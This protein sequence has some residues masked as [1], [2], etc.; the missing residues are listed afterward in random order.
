MT[1]EKTAGDDM[2]FPS[3]NYHSSLA[4]L[5]LT[6]RELF[7]AMAMQGMTASCEPCDQNESKIAQWAVNKA[8][9]LI[10]ALNQ[11]PEP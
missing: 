10:A 3:D 5:G 1:S 6:K 8:D 7:A 11:E 2:A 4:V 9:A